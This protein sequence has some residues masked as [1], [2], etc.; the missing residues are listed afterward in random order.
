LKIQKLVL[1]HVAHRFAD[2]AFTSGAHYRK[3]GGGSSSGGESS[4]RQPQP[5]SLLNATIVELHTT[6]GL[7]GVGE[8]PVS[9]VYY[10]NTLEVNARALKL[11]EEKVRGEEIDNLDRIGIILDRVLGQGGAAFNPSKD[12]LVTALLDVIGRSQGRP[13]FEVLGG[14]FRTAFDLN[15]NLLAPDAETMAE[16]ASE[17]VK[18]GYKALK[19]KC[20]MEIMERGWSQANSEREAM[21]VVKTLEAVPETVSVDG[22]C[23]QA[24]SPAPR[25]IGLIKGY[26]LDE[27]PNFSIEQPVESMDLSGA[28]AIR[29][30]T[31]VRVILDES[32]LSYQAMIA[33]IRTAA[34]D[35]VVVKPPRV[36]GLAESRRIIATAEAAHV[37]PCVDIGPSSKI[38]VSAMC[39]LAAT[40]KEPYPICGALF[41]LFQ[42]DPVKRGGVRL[43]DHKIKIEP[44]PGL[45]IELD[46][47][48]L[49]EIEV[50]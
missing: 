10:G 4:E 50:K 25:A 31:R 2:H 47:D 41:T 48:V 44:G 21:R 12:G 17:F 49:N 14:S 19:V 39:H 5:S 28:N 32:V 30:T 43:M 38:A 13:I 26:K 22:D 24:W 8:A 37:Q 15:T 6:T 3:G 27:Y 1:H 9:P 46:Y 29:R 45:G 23:N 20:G 16:R 40:M 7:V 11:F 42:H 18:L 34:A 36:G 35:R 33:I